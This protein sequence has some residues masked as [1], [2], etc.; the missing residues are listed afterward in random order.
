M[1][2][3]II[4]GVVALI[5]A[6]GLFYGGV[7]YGQAQTSGGMTRGQLMMG[8]GAAA[9]FNRMGGMNRQGGMM[10]MNFVAGE[11][12]S[13]DATSIT[14]KLPDGGSKIVFL[15]ASTTISKSVNGTIADLEVGKTVTV[16]GKT[17]TDGSVTAQGV[18]LRSA[19]P[20][21]RAPAQ[22]Q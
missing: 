20:M 6:G 9:G 19:F 1:N 16:D 8:Q 12:I 13:K 15:S 14:I 3:K 4:A 21:M 17:N 10:R 11:I 2:K 22:A 7:K 5:I 18:Q